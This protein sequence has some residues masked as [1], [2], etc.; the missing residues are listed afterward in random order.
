MSRDGDRQAPPRPRAQTT[1]TIVGT[2]EFSVDTTRW[3][4]WQ[5]AYRYGTLVIRPPA[6]VRAVVDRWRAR[7]DP[8]SQGYV[9]THIT[10]TQPFRQEPTRQAFAQI[11]TILRLQ[12]QFEIRYGPL[13]NFLPDPVL[14]LE[15]QPA[16]RVMA[17]R[18]ALHETGL[19]DLSQPHTDGFVP[20]MSIAEGLSSPQADEALYAQLRGQA[21]VGKFPCRSIT[22]LRPDERFQFRKLRTFR[23]PGS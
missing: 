1:P 6:R 8:V 7:Y 19:F 22:Y 15:V 17:L 4:A 2:G 16:R 3:P 10:V 23:L 12:H 13:R 9:D 11:T 14:W 21:P 18:R 5:R 20:H